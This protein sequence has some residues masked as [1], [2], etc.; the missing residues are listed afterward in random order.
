[1]RVLLVSQ[2]PP[3]LPTHERARLAPAY[4]L[5]HLAERHTI[6]LL[7]PEPRGETPAQQA[8]ASTLAACTLRVPVKRWRQPLT[9]APADGI[10]AFRAAALRAIEEWG[11][12]VVHLDGALLAPLAGSLPAPV[13]VACRDSGVRRARDAR[14]LARTARAWMR[15]QLEER[16]ESDWERRWLPAASA[17]VVGSED[18][19][20]TLAERVP[21]ERIDVIPPG[22]DEQR[23]E[24]RRAGEPAR[25]VF[26]GNLA[27]PTHLDA[28]R[29]LAARVLPR[30]RRTV[31]HAELLITG[32][33]P[34]STLRE[35]SSLPGVRASGVAPDLRPSVWS[36]GVSLVPAEAGPGVDA[37]LLESMALGT[38]VVAARRCLSGLT[39]VLPGHHLLEAESDDE[40]AAAAL[41]VLREPVVAATLAANARQLVER[42]YTW[43]AIARSW[44]SLWAR[45]ADTAPAAVAA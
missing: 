1:M 22:I 43:A 26:A 40:M 13:V 15:A 8:W 42:R 10:A 39:H 16:L 27:W 25:L 33:G 36:A 6:A 21:F 14:R 31:G 4:L 34:A 28:A 19:R 9:G 5:A 45:A 30:V 17:C 23:Y 12:D 41:L 7:T 35:L 3:H 44:E 37:A 11:P 38:P 20:Q 29:R 32:A 18:D 24:L 2:T